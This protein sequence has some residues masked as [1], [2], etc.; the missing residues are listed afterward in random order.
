MR[1]FNFDAFFRAYVDA[2]L[3]STQGPSEDPFACEN[4][5]DLFDVDDLAP[6]CA[7]SLRETCTDFCKANHADLQDYCARMRN[8]QWSGEERAGHDFWLT[9]N[10]HGA[11]FWDRGL[12][13][14]G[15]RLTKAAQVY[16][17]I[18]L[19]PGDDGLIY[20]G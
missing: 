9:Q 3:W 18:D 16:G 13:D 14:L 7:Q 8:E 2:A 1:N 17:S 12:D 4:L 6:A 11:G 10:G 20:G 5:A 15:Q 19:Y